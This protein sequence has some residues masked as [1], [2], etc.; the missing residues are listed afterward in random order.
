MNSS[1]G[2]LRSSA[3]TTTS[4]IAAATW[5]PETGRAPGVVGKRC[6]ECEGGHS[7]EEDGCEGAKVHVDGVA[8]S[9]MVFVKTGWYD[10]PICSRA[11]VGLG[12]FD[13]DLGMQKKGR[14]SIGERTDVLK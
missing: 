9:L 8:R 3:T 2:S 10:R 14:T 1:S 12:V 11:S 13:V 4:A 7:D 6:S 5:P